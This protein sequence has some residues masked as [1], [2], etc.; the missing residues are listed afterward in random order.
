[1][2]CDAVGRVVAEVSVALVGGLAGDPERVGDLSPRCTPMLRAVDEQ[3]EL[4]LCVPHDGDLP[5]GVVQSVRL[6]ALGPFHACQPILTGGGCQEVLTA[7]SGIV[8][9]T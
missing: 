4:V 3:L 5:A 8:G 7:T 6:V 2:P 1:M 9:V